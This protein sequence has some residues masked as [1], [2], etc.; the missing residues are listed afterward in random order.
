MQWLADESGLNLDWQEIPG[1]YL[2]FVTQRA[3]TLAEARDVINMHLLDRG[4]TLLLR[5]DVL[6]VT[7]VSKIDPSRVPRAGGRPR[8]APTA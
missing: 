1:D 7:A 5:G 8:T 4:Y 6:S 3:Y 2:N